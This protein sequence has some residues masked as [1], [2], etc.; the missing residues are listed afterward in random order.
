MRTTFFLGA[1]LVG[2]TNLLAQSDTLQTEQLSE[3]VVHATRATRTTPMAYTNITKETLARVNFGQDIPYLLSATPSVTMSSDGGAGIGYTYLRIRGIDPTRINVTNNGIPLND[4]ESNSLYWV[5]MGDFASSIGSVQVQRGV[6]TSTIGSGAFGASVNMQTEPISPKAFMQ[7]DGSVGSYGTH[8][9][10]LQFSTGRLG[11]HWGL[12]GRLSHIATDGYIDRAS[13]RLN[14]YFLQAGYFGDKTEV[15]FITFNGAERTYHAWDY[16]TRDEMEAYGR[17]YNPCGK[18]KDANG[19]T[20]YYPDQID[21]YNQQHYQLL[22][23]QRF[24]PELTLNAALHYTRGGGYYEQMKTNRKL[25]EYGLE[26]F[27]YRTADDE[28]IISKSR[29][30]LVRRK[31]SEADFYGTVVSLQYKKDK[32]EAI[33][34]GGWN[35]YDG[36]HHGKVLWVRNY[37]GD[38]NALQ[39]YYRNFAH[40]QD[41]NVFGRMEYAF[42]RNLTAY[43]D[44]QY[45]YVHY[46]M[47]GPCDEWYGPKDPVVFNFHNTFH[48][49][50]PKVG[51]YYRITPHH[52]LYASYAMAHKEPTRNDYEAAVWSQTPRAERLNDFELGYKFRSERFSAVVN[53]YY[54]LY[55]DQF[56]QTGEQD[57]NGEFIMQN[58]GNSYRRGVELAL[59]WK[60]LDWLRWHGNLT[61]SHN[62]IKDYHVI[63]DDT[64]QPFNLGNT[65]IS[66]S[67]SLIFNNIFSF[68]WKGLS[69]AVHT[70]YVGKQYMT[71]TGFES[72]SEGTRDVSLLLDPYCTTNLDLSY[73]FTCIPRV[74]SLTLGVAVFNLFNAKYESNGAAYTCVKS[75]GQGG[76]MAY[77]D[78]DWNSYAVFAAQAPTNFLFH[79]S[80]RF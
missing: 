34:G 62:R 80:I 52:D 75:N 47:Y 54:M 46:D 4:A 63:L 29:A 37:L 1:A 30:D 35:K 25:Y 7:F 57:K 59:D 3:A 66:Y 22:W 53:F 27:S 60:P 71:N 32:W 40:K 21:S 61:W 9:E 76:A 12:S 42:M 56:V 36:V 79:L 73:T 55:K 19:N 77:Q 68:K 58:V 18:Y 31:Y 70:Q 28:E 13:V 24:L 74:K 50:N 41:A 14:S 20:L 11:G 10:S 64:A 72:Y 5:N 67:P 39:P 26:P 48:F 23:T 43:A 45:R 44:L 51:L 17:T 8:K 69:A 65:P 33:L 15:K 38:I 78:D 16:A 2:C 6:G 49:F